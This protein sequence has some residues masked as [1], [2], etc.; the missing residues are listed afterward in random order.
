MKCK[1]IS[2]KK[3]MCLST[4]KTKNV[5]LFRSSTSQVSDSPKFEK[6]NNISINVFCI[7]ENDNAYSIKVCD[8]KKTDHIDLLYITE[9]KVTP[10]ISSFNLL[11]GK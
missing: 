9:K 1:C 3:E 8:Q 2:I 6:A 11:V 4:V 7:D 10:Y 5:A